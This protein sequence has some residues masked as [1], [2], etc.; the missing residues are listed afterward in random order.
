MA[1]HVAHPGS[2]GAG[3]RQGRRRRAQVAGRWQAVVEATSRGVS[4]GEGTRRRPSAT[5]VRFMLRS[6]GTLD[7]LF[8]LACCPLCGREGVPLDLRHVLSEHSGHNPPSRGGSRLPV[9]CNGFVNYI[10]I[11]IFLTFPIRC[12][13]SREVPHGDDSPISPNSGATFPPI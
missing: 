5:G 11:N 2:R 4:G 3:S 12:V 7:G 8:G 1:G 10:I 9:R 6:G 13:H